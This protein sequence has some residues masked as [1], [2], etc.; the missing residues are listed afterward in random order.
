MTV[1][2]MR[3]SGEPVDEDVEYEEYREDIDGVLE[4]LEAVTWLELV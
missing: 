1:W 3:Q 4:R 2:E